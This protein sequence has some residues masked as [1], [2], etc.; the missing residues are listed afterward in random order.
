M[1]RDRATYIS[2]LFAGS[3]ILL[4]CGYGLFCYS[5]SSES[6][7]TRHFVSGIDSSAAIYIG[8]TEEHRFDEFM[9]RHAP[10]RTPETYLQSGIRESDLDRNDWSE[11]A[12]YEK[13]RDERETMVRGAENAARSRAALTK[14]QSKLTASWPGLPGSSDQRV[15]NANSKA[16]TTNPARTTGHIAT[17]R[18]SADRPSHALTENPL[19]FRTIVAT[20]QSLYFAIRNG[21]HGGRSALQSSPAEP[22]RFSCSFLFLLFLLLLFFVF[23]PSRALR[24]HSFF[25]V[26]I[27]CANICAGHL[28]LNI[29][30]DPV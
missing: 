3:G 21:Y 4:V 18:W 6:V 19:G 15:Q 26:N 16:V 14:Q 28:V 29:P 20:I 1:L 11:L 25:S 23:A 9:V 17:K 22:I 30:G 13:I 27:H 2:E 5:V 10:P 7:S 24:F 8:L 12:A